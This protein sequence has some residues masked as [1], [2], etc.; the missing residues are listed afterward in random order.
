VRPR[1]RQGLYTSTIPN[2][3]NLTLEKNYLLLEG[4]DFMISDNKQVQITISAHRILSMFL[5]F[6]PSRW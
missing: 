5:L 2:V 3:A 4:L 1:L 6:G